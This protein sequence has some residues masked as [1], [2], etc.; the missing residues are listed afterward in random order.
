[1]SRGLRSILPYMLIHSNVWISP[2]VSV[3]GMKYFVTFIDCY[4]R[5]SWLYLMRHKNEVLKCFQN[6]Y[7]YIKNHFNAKIQFIRTDNVG[8]YLNSEFGRLLSLEGILHQTSWPD[9]PLQNGVTERKNRRILEITRSLMYAMNVPK[10]LWS[11]AI[12]TTT[13]LINRTSSRI[14]GMN[15]PC[16]MILGKNEFIVPQL[17]LLC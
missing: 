3:S 17:H 8:E 7:T 12:M 9:T 6:F 15:T 16:E 1:V 10:F 5:M 11:E 4:S 2:V 14:L 13:Y